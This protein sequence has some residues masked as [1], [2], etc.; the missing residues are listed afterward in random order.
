MHLIDITI[1]ILYILFMLGIGIYFMRK[2]NDAEDYY[3][4]GREMGAW[5]VGLSIV[6]TDV[7]GGFSIGLGGLG[8]MVGIAGSWMLFTG[9]VGAWLAAILLVPRV[10]KLETLKKFYTFPQLL[11]HFYGA[12][13]AVVAALISAIGYA[14]FTSSQILAGAKLVNATF[15]EISFLWATLMMG[16]IAIIYTALGGIKAVIY[17]D[18][19]QWLILIIGL[20]FIG[21]PLAYYKVGGYEVIT[22]TLDSKYFSL[23]NISWQ[24]AINWV[25][26]IIPI[27]FIAMT[28]YQRIYACKGEQEAKKAFFIAGCFEW[29]I[30]AFMGVLLGLFAK[31]AL[32]N[33]MFVDLGVSGTAIDPELSIPLILRKMFPVGVLGIMLAAYFSA[34]LSTAD[35]CLMASSGNILTDILQ[36]MIKKE[37]NGKNLLLLSQ[38]VTF[39]IGGLALL[40]A[41][42]LESVLKMMLYS[43]GVMVSG[44][45]IPTVFALFSKKSSKIAALFSM[46]TGSTIILF[47]AISKSKVIFD[48]DPNILGITGSLISYL[49]TSYVAKRWGKRNA[50]EI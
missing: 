26:T 32:L 1:V 41:I 13:I 2:N 24:M 35:S 45:F 37:L 47:F 30:M 50:K 8:F 20:F 9:I 34:I 17:T 6:A 21:I 15:S 27:W 29:P 43:Y 36:R 48:L 4:G 42:H 39:I 31:V 33:G 18:T 7:G 10:K 5:H 25:V 14:G 23:T 40:L 22:S 3:V 16:V 44:L 49:L 38:L 11:E 19:F 46:I 28:L 12:K